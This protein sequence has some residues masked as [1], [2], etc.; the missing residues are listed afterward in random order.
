MSNKSF[1]G[2]VVERDK[3][4]I[5]MRSELQTVV[6]DLKKLVSAD[7]ASLTEVRQ[8]IT[9]WDIRWDKCRLYL[10]QDELSVSTMATVAD[11]QIIALRNLEAAQETETETLKRLDTIRKQIDEAENSIKKLN[12]MEA[13][14]MLRSAHTKGVNGHD[15]DAEEFR[16]IR[17]KIA[18]VKGFISLREK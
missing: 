8:E 17:Q 11:L 12:S 15:Q 16:V 5:A 6:A 9:A 4:L 13:Y 10:E 2:T 3:N 7:T 14:Q 18:T 1:A